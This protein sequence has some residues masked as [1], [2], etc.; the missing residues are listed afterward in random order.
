MSERK[1]LI[2]FTS[3][4][5]GSNN[6]NARQIL[7]ESGIIIINLIISLKFTDSINQTEFLD[8]QYIYNFYY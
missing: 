2:K 8:Y 7:D 6:Y 3:I 4:R 1:Y 5:L